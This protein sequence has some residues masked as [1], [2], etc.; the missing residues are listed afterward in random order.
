MLKDDRQGTDLNSID[1][2]IDWL[3]A[4]A[5]VVSD[6]INNEWVRPGV[7]AQGGGLCGKHSLHHLQS[8]L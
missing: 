5:H 3:D 1:L 7:R 2:E 4:Q 8:L 6:H